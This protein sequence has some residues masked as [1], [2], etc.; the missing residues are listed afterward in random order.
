MTP[1]IKI[2]LERKTLLSI[3]IA[4]SI[5]V[6]LLFFLPTWLFASNETISEIKI[7]HLDKW[8][9]GILFFML[10]YLWQ[11]Y[12]FKLNKHTISKSTIAVLFII[13][14]VYGIIIEVFQELTPVSR[15][16]DLLDFLADMLGAVLGIL[17][18]KIFKNKFHS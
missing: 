5:A 18:F 16:G 11:W 8:V 3:A 1:L 2:S 17:T 7:P 12:Y 14:M 9:H 15:S 13:L 4:Y 10:V 6:S